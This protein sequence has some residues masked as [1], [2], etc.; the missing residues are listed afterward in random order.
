MST[1]SPDL[2]APAAV[3]AP[4]LWRHPDFRRLWIGETLSLYGTQVT[5]LA[6]PLAAVTAFGASPAQ[7]GLLRFLQLVPYLGLALLLGAWVDRRRKRPVLIG[8][9]VG[10]MALIAAVPVL[11]WTHQLTMGW[12]LVVAAAVGI[13]SVLFDVTWM[14]FVPAVVADPTRYVE[15]NQKLGV[16]A[17]SA[18]VAGPGL[19]GLLVGLLGAPVAL[20][21][22]ATSYVASLMSL[23]AVRAAEPTPATGPRRHLL[24]EVREG[25]V[26][27]AA[28]R[29]LRP[30]ALLG[31]LCNFFMVSIWTT[32]LLYAART[33]HLSPGL[34]GLV[35]SASSV[36]GLA[37]GLLSGRLLGS[38]RLGAVYVA[39]MSLVFAGPLLLVLADGSAPRVVAWSIGSFFVGYLGLGVAN[40]VMVSLRQTCTPPEMMGRMN[41]AFRTL[42][43][44]GGSLGALAGGFVAGAVGLRPALLGL[45]VCSAGAVVLVVCSPV[46]RLRSIADAGRG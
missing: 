24:A 31:P 6:L 12:L 29:V 21:V 20:A 11:H 41:A 2:A 19:A 42:L 16:T 7:V 8:T 45:A 30:L 22:D 17:S 4:S 33:Q 38:Y 28:H 18:D 37:G 3:G 32:F 26:H 46:G 14:S 1:Q 35:F 39:A 15:A 25:V 23:S 43:F 9:N 27:V 40:V 34:I 44:G 36:G 5:T 13:C 10:R